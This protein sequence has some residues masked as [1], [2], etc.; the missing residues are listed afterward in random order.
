MRI[1]K[2]ETGVRHENK[3]FKAFS[4]NGNRRTLLILMGIEFHCLGPLDKDLFQRDFKPVG[5]DRRK[6]LSEDRIHTLPG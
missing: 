2:T 3:C 6:L 5:I 1:K 4:E